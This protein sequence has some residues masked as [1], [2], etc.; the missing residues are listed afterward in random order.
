M[1]FRAKPTGQSQVLEM[2]ARG[3]PLEMVLT[4]L[5]LLIEAQAEETLCSVLLLSED[6]AHIPHGAAPSLPAAHQAAKPKS[7]ILP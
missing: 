4:S 2:I 3:E 1:T 7:K 6:G 5:M